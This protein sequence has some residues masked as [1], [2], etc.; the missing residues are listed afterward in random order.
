MCKSHFYENKQQKLKKYKSNFMMK[1]SNSSILNS[2]VTVNEKKNEDEEYEKN[3]NS[4]KK[5]IILEPKNYILGNLK[6]VHRHLECKIPIFNGHFF[7]TYIMNV[8]DNTYWDIQRN[9]KYD[10]FVNK[11]TSRSQLRSKKTSFI[12]NHTVSINKEVNDNRDNVCIGS[13]LISKKLIIFEKNKE[14]VSNSSKFSMV[15]KKI[16][17]SFL[18]EG[19]NIIGQKGLMINL[20][21]NKSLKKSKSVQK[22]NSF[23][24]K[25]DFYYN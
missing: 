6:K 8:D 12:E 3:S 17:R 10:L 19:E 15:L 9:N 20:P 25:R 14:N 13:K 24:A 16:S 7:R 2:F 4:L 22:V 18:K 5:K 21:K 11:F 23:F 1:K